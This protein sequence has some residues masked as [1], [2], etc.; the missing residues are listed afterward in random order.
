MK[1]VF[2]FDESGCFIG[3]VII[4]DP[5]EMQSDMTEEPVPQ[6]CIKPRWDGSNW[7][8]EG[9]LD[10]LALEN[11]KRQKLSEIN[12]KAKN[13][14][15]HIRNAYPQFEIDTWTEQKD[16][17]LAYQNDTSSE[18]PMLL[19][20][21]EARGLSV[22]ELVLRVLAKVES[23]RDAVS[24]VTGIRQRLEDEVQGAAT[25]SQVESIDWP[26]SL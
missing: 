4:F 22:A 25:I 12:E 19:G 18:T 21:A 23:Y 16:E 15:A 26:E 24:R 14:V 3:D 7:I 5:S 9:D 6:P 8:E 13:S 11:S 17:A 1:K 10:E 20:I 2:Q